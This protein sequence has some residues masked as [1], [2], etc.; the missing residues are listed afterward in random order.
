M[1]SNTTT[2]YLA[3]LCDKF[4]DNKYVVVE[5]SEL[6][7]MWKDAPEDFDFDESFKELK[8]NDCII[9][10]YK[11]ED[12]VCF[13]LTDKARVLIQEYRVFIEQAV[14]AQ[15]T[16]KKTVAKKG[17]KEEQLSAEQKEIIKDSYVQAGADGRAVMIMPTEVAEKKKKFEFKRIKQNAFASGF[18][19]GL[20]GG[21]VFGLIFGIIGGIIAKLIF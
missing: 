5:W 10:K 3:E 20:V 18:L 14:A 15:Q 13:T 12:E 9:Y 7:S 1:L 4:P 11:D 16:A 19:G 6:K 2:R 17:D 8:M 21:L